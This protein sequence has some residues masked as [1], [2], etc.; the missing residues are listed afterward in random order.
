MQQ[1]VKRSGGLKPKDSRVQVPGTCLGL[2]F[3]LAAWHYP[4][5]AF[6][7][8]ETRPC[9]RWRTSDSMAGS[10]LQCFLSLSRRFQCAAANATCLL[11]CTCGPIN[12][13]HSIK[14][15]N[16]GP[17]SDL[18]PQNLHL[19]KVSRWLKCTLKCEEFIWK[20]IKVV[21]T[22][23]TALNLSCVLMV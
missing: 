8:P 2:Y 15:W 18:P 1:Q 16:L 14:M 17:T 5:G 19:S 23:Y 22:I 13:Y 3:S 21:K 11:L 6:Q 9:S 10:W 7:I 20:I 12:G 4:L